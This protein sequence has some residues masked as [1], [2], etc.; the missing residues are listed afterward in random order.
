MTYLSSIKKIDYY[1]GD[2]TFPAKFPMLNAYVDIID[3][4]KHQVGFYRKYHMDTNERPDTLS[5]KLYDTPDYHWTFYLIND[6][7]R[8]S[9]WPFPEYMAYEVAK[10]RFPNTCILTQELDKLITS[11]KI[12]DY[13][14]FPSGESL[15]IIARDLNVGQITLKGTLSRDNTNK[16]AVLQDNSATIFINRQVSEELGV[17]HYADPDGKWVDIDPREEPAEGLNPVTFYQYLR[18]YNEKLRV[19][20]IIK[21]DAIA[22]IASEISRKLSK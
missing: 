4:V 8:E 7:I 21:S 19:I 15:P 18:D 17:H 6:D 9:G 13:V 2:E 3:Q 22:R 16:I 10:K 1:F 5:Y 11:F 12:G 20:N 14:K